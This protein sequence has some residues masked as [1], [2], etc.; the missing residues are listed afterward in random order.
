MHSDINNGIVAGLVGGIVFGIMM[1]MMNAPTPRGRAD[2]DDGHGG[3]G[4][5]LRQHRCRL[6]LP[7]VQQRS[8]WR[9]FWLATWL[10]IASVWR[11]DRM[12]R[13]LR[14]R[15]V[16]LGRA[17][18]DAAV[19]RHGGFCAVS[20]GAHAACRDGESHGP[21]HLWHYSWRRR[22]YVEA[23]HTRINPACIE[24]L[25]VPDSRGQ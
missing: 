14:I 18:I 1:Q 19:S 9:Y 6:D 3:H 12:G 2:A 4:S 21:S 16:D 15:M 25:K 13:S 10:S 7:F 23:G 11:R 20:D 17:D 8:Y 5:A 22:C 24:L